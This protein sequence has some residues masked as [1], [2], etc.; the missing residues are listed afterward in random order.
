MLRIAQADS[1]QHTCLLQVLGIYADYYVF[2]T[3]LKEQADE[4]ETVGESGSMQDLHA[5]AA[6]SLR[7]FSWP[8]LYEAQSTTMW[9]VQQPVPQKVEVETSNQAVLVS[10]FCSNAD[11]QAAS[12]GAGE[13]PSEKGGGTNGYTYFV[14]NSL[15][16]PLSKLPAVKPTQIKAARLIKKYLTGKLDASVSLHQSA[17]VCFLA[18]PTPLPSTSSCAFERQQYLRYT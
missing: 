12:V 18:E 9:C 8:R 1:Q 13:V 15:G 14:C 2:E 4:E 7:L 16:G 6:V 10:C 17:P 5:P 11:Q 3:T